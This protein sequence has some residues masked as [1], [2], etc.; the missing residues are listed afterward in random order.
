MFNSEYDNFRK[1]TLLSGKEISAG[2][3][4]E[5]NDLLVSSS[6]RKDLLLHTKEPGSP[7][8]NIGEE[9]TKEEIYEAATFCAL[10]SQ[11][12]RDN[13]NDVKVHLFSKDKCF[14][15]SSMKSGSW[16]VKKNIDTIKVKKNG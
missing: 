12:F 8:V 9:A 6:S 13:Q 5:Q 3:D 14:K 10:K 16:C 15:D 1:F 2:K 7:F 11:D 4:S